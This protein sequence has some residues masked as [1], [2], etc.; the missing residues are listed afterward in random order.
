MQKNIPFTP[1]DA[2]FFNIMTLFMGPPS[3]HWQWHN[4]AVESV[5]VVP[6][7]IAVE[8]VV[9]LIVLIGT[10]AIKT[11][12]NNDDAMSLHGRACGVLPCRRQQPKPQGRS[13]SHEGAARVCK[14]AA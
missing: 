8:V 11:T 1:P 4:D 7:V 9:I 13:L 12:S 3:G 2:P 10:N 6:A 14:D 5:V